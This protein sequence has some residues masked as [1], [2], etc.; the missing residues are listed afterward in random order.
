MTQD[1][2][3][4]VMRGLVVGLLGL[5]TRMALARMKRQDDAEAA[6]NLALEEHRE[7]TARNLREF[8]QEFLEQ[9]ERSRRS[10]EISLTTLNQTMAEV[11]RTAADI[12]AYMAERYATKPEL[13]ALEERIQ[14]QIRDLREERRRN[15]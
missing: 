5:M 13:R 10:T 12:K 7:T 4:W 9:L 1:F 6:F 2:E 15:G 14:L 3:V 11:A 8:R